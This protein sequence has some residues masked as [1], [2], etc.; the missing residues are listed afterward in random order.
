M[1]VRSSIVLVLSVLLAVCVG[2][3]AKK[4]KEGGLT[5]KS[6]LAAR[7]DN[8]KITEQ[9]MLR[10][11]EELSDQQQKEFKGRDGQAKFVDRLME[12]ELLYRAALDKGLDKD[13]EVRRKIENT[14]SNILAG[15]Y[16]SKYIL[17]KIKVTDADISA[18]Y[19]EHKSEF[20]N[21]PVLK[22]QYLYTVDSLKAVAWRKKLKGGAN[23]NKLAKEESEDRT[24]APALGDL[25]Y[26]NLGGYVRAIGYNDNF[27]KAVD[28]L[29]VGQISPV[30][31][32]EKG[33]GIVKLT[34]RNPVKV[35]ELA[36]VS[37]MIE[38]KLMR[39]KSED[40]YKQEINRLKA[41]Y[42]TENYVRE[43]LS[44]STRTAE[45]LWEMAQME[46]NPRQRIQYYRDIVN[47]YPTNK[48]APQALF[49]IGFVY[50]E[51]LQDFV[52]AR[53]TFDELEKKYPE[54]DMIQSA[55][56]MIDNMQKP[57]PR[58]DSYEKM[59]K[60]MEGGKGRTG[61]GGK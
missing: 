37:K 39:Q 16:F 55:K 18:Y 17:D 23:F 35:Q 1:K 27:T 52:Q 2:S 25:G 58:F 45:E 26:F 20:V 49:M 14:T 11:F 19:N 6:G 7:V 21:P 29:A 59:Q 24:V 51:D 36:D 46:E 3:C 8:V 40:M 54:S 41:K 28:T 9:E 31:R 56:W 34:E 13:D 15:E 44:A 32:L 42:P 30:I 12:Q 61:T 47:L 10:R 50:A 33:Y 43:M 5:V 48:N 38:S 22:A 60:A 53:R 57:G 4:G